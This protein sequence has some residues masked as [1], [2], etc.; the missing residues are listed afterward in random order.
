MQTYIEQDCTIEHN[1]HKFTSGGAV[2]TDSHIVGY[3]RG[4]DS[5]VGDRG[6]FVSWRGEKLGTYVIISR[7][8][9]N[10][11]WQS[12]HRIAARVFING[13]VY[14]GRGFGSGMLFRG[15]RVKN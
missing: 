10:N 15:K 7:W 14:S 5:R 4:P 1:G 6:E 8:R 12:T 3:L 11:S 13:V 9:V 2:V